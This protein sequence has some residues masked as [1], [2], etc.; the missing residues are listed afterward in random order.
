MLAGL[1]NAF[2]IWFYLKALTEDESSV[3]VPFMQ[4][5]P[6][7]TFLLGY[8]FLGE[9]LTPNQMLG[10]VIIIIGAA[11]LSLELTAGQPVRIKLKIV[12]LMIGCSF[13]FALYT[14][15]FKFVSITEG[16]WLGAFW[17]AIGLILSGFIFFAV[18]SYREEFFQV[19]RD[20]S[21]PIIGLNLL[22]EAI[23][24]A[25]NWVTTF[26]SL[27]IPVALVSL[28]AG[29][30]PLFVFIIG[31]LLTLFIPKIAAEDISRQALVQK[32]LAIAIV[33]YGTY[34]LF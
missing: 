15:L 30:Q 26:S 6:I 31:I 19:F 9:L 28:I 13:L 10:G 5:I 22:N 18:K 29:Y 4:L 16:F 2:A 17:E 3:V 34:L 25:G 33:I 20:N 11:I 1:A 12:W 27:L 14:V 8:L 32:I 23:T 7:F 21:K 24:I